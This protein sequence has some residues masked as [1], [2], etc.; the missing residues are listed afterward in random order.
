MIGVAVMQLVGEGTEQTVPVAMKGQYSNIVSV[1][2]CVLYGRW[3][4][5]ERSFLQGKI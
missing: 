1:R 2:V 3:N 5:F 4:H